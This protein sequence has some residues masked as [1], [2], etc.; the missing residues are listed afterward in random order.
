MNGDGVEI[1]MGHYKI[2]GQKDGNRVYL[3]FYQSSTL[4]AR[5][6]AIETQDDFNQTPI[7]FVQLHPYNAQRVKVI[8][9]SIDFNAYTFIRIKEEISD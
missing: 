9:G 4:V 5:V 3:D 1:P 2:V 6:P 7:N 8:Y